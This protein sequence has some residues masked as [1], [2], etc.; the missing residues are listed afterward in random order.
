MNSYAIKITITKYGD[1]IFTKTEPLHKGPVVIDTNYSYLLMRTYFEPDV[2]IL[3][4]EIIEINP[5]IKV[6]IKCK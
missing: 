5:K 4:R 6:D 3:E 1:T 2:Y